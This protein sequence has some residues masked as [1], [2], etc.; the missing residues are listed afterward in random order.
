MSSPSFVNIDKWLFELREGNLSPR[1][2]DELNAF[3][4]AHPEFQ[5][6][7]EMW[8]MAKVD[9]EAVT[10]PNAADLERKST[11][12]YFGLAAV[13]LLVILFVSSL[14]NTNDSAPVY[15]LNKLDLSIEEKPL[16]EDI[17]VQ[18]EEREE[19]A[20]LVNPSTRIFYVKKQSSKDQQNFSGLNERFTS[21][22][23]S[24]INQK[25]EIAIAENKK[26][27]EVLNTIETYKV[28]T[29]NSTNKKIKTQIENLITTKSRCKISNHLDDVVASLNGDDTPMDI[30]E[31]DPTKSISKLSN[32][33]VF[34]RKLRKSLKKL[35]DMVNNPIALRNFRDPNY[36]NP[37]ATDFTFNPAMTGTQ[38]RSRLQT[39]G[40]VSE[41]GSSR[42]QISSK[43]AFDT[44]LRALRGG[45]GIDV[46]HSTTDKGTLQNYELGF[47][48]SPK[49]TV[50]KIISVEPGI[51]F[52]VGNKLLDTGKLLPGISLEEERGNVNTFFAE[53]EEPTGNS[54]WYRD[55]SLGL[56]INTPWFYIGGTVD[57]IGRH[58]NNIYS[59]DISQDYNADLYYNAQI[60]TDYVAQRRDL[61][62]STYVLFQK[63]ASFQELWLGS[64]LTVSNFHIGG[65]I[66]SQLEPAVS[67]GLDTDRFRL[68]YQG[69]YTQSFVT[70]NKTLNHQITLRYKF[71]PNRYALRLLNK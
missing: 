27:D 13:S 63:R 51:R 62:L 57:N 16:V 61:K 40:R 26:H 69:D 39:T 21:H 53:N 60:G 46:K 41:L 10:Y 71:K 11:V 50:K 44:Y 15:A 38:V 36:H 7:A 34:K 5:S 48:F 55:A 4:D 20:Q 59:N 42:E 35:Q 25:N 58:Y 17:I 47:S 23:N 8:G 43:I 14:F 9:K 22:R 31:I 52:K 19:I 3:L 66:S 28:N 18:Y 32:T 6:D 70:F 68:L 64:N 2:I 29:L 56:L 30:A 67:I 49:F 12:I 54:L 24:L 65:G 37:L 1:Q 45:L 33:S